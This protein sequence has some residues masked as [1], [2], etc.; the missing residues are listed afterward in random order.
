MYLC[1]KAMQ[2]ILMKVE[3]GIWRL[4]VVVEMLGDERENEGI[5]GHSVI[6]ASEH[7][8]MDLY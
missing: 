3:T 5:T 8:K 2:M 1:F 4:S 6:G 7:W